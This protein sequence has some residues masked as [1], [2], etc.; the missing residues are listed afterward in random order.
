MKRLEDCKWKRFGIIDLF[1]IN[2]GANVSKSELSDGDIPRITATDI[3]NGVDFFTEM[4]CNKNFRVY[5]NA[6]SISFLGSCFYQ[7]YLASYDM[8]IHSIALKDRMLNKYIAL[9]IVNQCKRTC[10]QVTYGNQMSSSDLKKQFVCLP[11]DSNNEPDYVFMENYMREVEHKQKDRYK[12][13]IQCKI[14]EVGFVESLENK[15]WKEFNL[16]D[17]FPYIQRGKRLK[18]RWKNN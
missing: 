1:E 6:V 9:F 7:P 8:K 16:K 10:G 3:N 14:K 5:E 12:N 15:K 17:I 4:S 13:Y 18:T 2:T 11:V